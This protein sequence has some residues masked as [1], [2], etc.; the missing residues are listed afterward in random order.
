MWLKVIIMVLLIGNLVAL[1][2]A[3]YT[4]MVDQ[5]R[6]GKRTANLLF[7]RVALA[8]LLLVA[9]AY[10]L[11]SGDLGISAPWYNPQN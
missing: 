8:V 11:W 1:G 5:G 3:F 7:V 4:L 6:A 10:G 9:V 2:S